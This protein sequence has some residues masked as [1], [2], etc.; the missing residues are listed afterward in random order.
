MKTSLLKQCI[1]TQEEQDLRGSY[2][3]ALV[4]RKVLK[5]ALQEKIDASNKASRKEEGYDSPNWAF[6]QADSRGY[7]RALEEILSFL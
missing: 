6:K 3:S 5:R 1:D 4:F 7:E 2:A